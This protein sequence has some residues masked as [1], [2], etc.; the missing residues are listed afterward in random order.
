MD[1][2]APET[3]GVKPAMLLGM[4]KAPSKAPAAAPKSTTKKSAGPV[5]NDAPVAPPMPTVEIIRGDKRTA[6]VI[7]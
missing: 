3:P 7:R 1:L 6:E 4:V 2:S 5:T